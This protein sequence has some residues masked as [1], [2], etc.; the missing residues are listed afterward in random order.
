MA[1]EPLP[2]KVI[3]TPYLQSE[4]LAADVKKRS[5][6]LVAPPDNKRHGFEG[7]PNQGFVFAL[8]ADYDGPLEPGL[9]VVFKENNPQGFKDPKDLDKRTFFSL[10]LDQ[11]IAV[12]KDPK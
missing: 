12:V 7:I 11:V 6:L 2:G 4:A 3:I 1:V 8:P 5:G 10:Q 9:R